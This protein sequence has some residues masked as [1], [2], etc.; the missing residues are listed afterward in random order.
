MS[1]RQY[2]QLPEK[3]P[4]RQIVVRRLINSII[5]FNH[6]AISYKQYQI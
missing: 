6:P 3:I 5:K 4:L 2:R 1:H